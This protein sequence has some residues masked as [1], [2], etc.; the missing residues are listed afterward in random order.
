MFAPSPQGTRLNSHGGDSGYITFLLFRLHQP[1]TWPFPLNPIW[2]FLVRHPEILPGSFHRGCPSQKGNGW[3]PFRHLR[4]TGRKRKSALERGVWGQKLPQV[5]FPCPSRQGRTNRF[6]WQGHFLCIVSLHF[7][8]NT[9]GNFHRLTTTNG[10]ARRPPEHWALLQLPLPHNFTTWSLP[11]LFP[12]SM[13]VYH[14]FLEDRDPI[15]LFLCTP[16]SKYNNTVA[17]RATHFP[18][19]KLISPHRHT[20]QARIMLISQRRG[21]GLEKVS[22]LPAVPQLLKGRAGTSHR[23]ESVLLHLCGRGHL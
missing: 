19:H 20:P 22:S 6:C 15:F 11:V 21:Q 16:D 8:Q 12:V 3:K 23:P 1:V 4:I 13:H 18:I 14:K 5:M 9:F 2:K 17:F 7:T 10:I